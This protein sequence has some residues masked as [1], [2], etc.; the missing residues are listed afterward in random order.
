MS[1]DELRGKYFTDWVAHQL[2]K[3]PSGVAGVVLL[4]ENIT[5]EV[6]RDAWTH[7]VRYTAKGIDL[8]DHDAAAEMLKERHPSWFVFRQDHLPTVNVTL[9]NAEE[10]KPDHEMR[11]AYSE[12]PDDQHAFC[13]ITLSG[14]TSAV[15]RSNWKGIVFLPGYTTLLEPVRNA[16]AYAIRYSAKGLEAPDHEAAC[17]LIL[18]RHPS[19]F[20]ANLAPHPVQVDLR[21]AQEDMP[22]A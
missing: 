21:N 2:Y 11:F 5:K 3:Y 17:E 22:E 10:D 15:S 12:K 4:K 9:A 20:I 7:A 16:W 18:E 8:P 1:L 14:Y 13:A 6:A 19:W